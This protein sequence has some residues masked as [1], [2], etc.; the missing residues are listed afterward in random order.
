MDE[1]K[2]REQVGEALKQTNSSFGQEEQRS[3]VRWDDAGTKQGEL[4]PF[5]VIRGLAFG[6]ENPQT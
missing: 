6:G 3:R 5:D 4:W 2:K 1:R